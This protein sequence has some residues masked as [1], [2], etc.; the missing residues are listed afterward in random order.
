MD[1]ARAHHGIFIDDLKSRIA[2]LKP[3]A[4]LTTSFMETIP[5]YYLSRSAFRPL[6]LPQAQE[7]LAYNK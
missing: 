1:R 3:E 5:N 6:N 7:N 4:F 2:V